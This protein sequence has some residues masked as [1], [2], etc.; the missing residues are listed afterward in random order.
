MVS[1]DESV[2]ASCVLAEDEAS[3]FRLALLRV[4]ACSTAGSKTLDDPSTA[5]TG[6]GQN[7]HM[8][9]TPRLSRGRWLQIVGLVRRSFVGI[10]GPYF[11]AL[12]KGEDNEAE[13]KNAPLTPSQ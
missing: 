8:P 11:H 6:V 12:S 7:T 1:A 4:V 2:I 3:N 10:K 5:A 9:A 13:Q